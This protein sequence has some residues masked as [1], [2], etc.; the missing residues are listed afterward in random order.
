MNKINVYR[1]VVDHI[2]TLKRLGS[3][4]C[5]PADVFIFFVLPILLG[6]LGYWGGA[7]FKSDVI[8]VIVTA[9]SIFAALLFNLLLLIYSIIQKPTTGATSRPLREQFLQEIYANISFTIFI[10]LLTISVAVVGMF[11][12]GSE[13]DRQ[14]T[15]A[16]ISTAILIAFMLNF[17]LTLLMILKRVHLLLSKEFAG[18]K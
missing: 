5:S 9:F 14:T 6:A 15:I 7:S 13:Q 8:N 12:A 11:W 17:V 4:S 2:R 10:S 16:R 1:I 3:D 18:E